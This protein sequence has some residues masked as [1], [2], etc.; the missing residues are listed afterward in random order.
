MDRCVLLSTRAQREFKKLPAHV[1]ERIRKALKTLAS[2]PRHSDIKRLKGIDGR[3]VLYRLR[4]GDYRITYYAE[5]DLIKIIRIDHR[6]RGYAWL[7]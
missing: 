1:R 3:K 4:V 7:D 2:D 6:S 5:S